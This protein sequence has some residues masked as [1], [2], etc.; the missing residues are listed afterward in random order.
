MKN[1]FVMSFVDDLETVNKFDEFGFVCGIDDSVNG[2]WCCERDLSYLSE[3]E[4]I[5]FI[6]KTSKELDY[7]VNVNGENFDKEDIELIKNKLN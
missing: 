3:E 4:V 7:F 2:I 1:V 6:E 5:N